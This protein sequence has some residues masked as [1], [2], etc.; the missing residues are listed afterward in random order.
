M[1]Y[2]VAAV[3]AAVVAAVVNTLKRKNLDCTQVEGYSDFT[4]RAVRL[5]RTAYAVSCTSEVCICQS[6]CV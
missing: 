2:F 5:H 3:A 4:G 1:R 6:F